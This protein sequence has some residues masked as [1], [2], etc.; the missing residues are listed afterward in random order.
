MVFSTV[1]GGFKLSA[2]DERV[3]NTQRGIT[4][5]VN[6]KFIQV[7]AVYLRTSGKMPIDDDWAEKHVRD[8]NL[9]DWIDDEQLRMANVGFNLQMGWMDI[10]ID[11]E[12]PAFNEC[13]VAALDYNGVD[14]RFRFGRRSVGYPTHVLVQLGEDEASNFEEL[15]RFEPR[16]FRIG[17]KRYHTQL[18]SY[19]TN[20]PDKK[21]LYRSAKQTVMPGSVY[22]HKTDAD[23]YDLSVWYKRGGIAENVQELAATTPR[24]AGFNQVVRAIAFATFVYVLRDH[25]V[26]G[27]RQTTVNKVAGWLARVV[28]DGQA[29]NNH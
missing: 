13:M 15:S 23:Q 16:E 28:A 24:R 11:A 26:E 6:D 22:L 12:D 2:D 7:G 1:P 18:R 14:T 27:S 21:N 9:Q 19:P 8:T 20:I 25:W 29:I 5:A 4:R 17:G 10:D 3:V